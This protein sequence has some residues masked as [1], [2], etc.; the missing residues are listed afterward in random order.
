MASLPEIKQHVKDIIAK[1]LNL[2]SEDLDELQSFHNLGL[3]SVNSI[4]LLAK[5]EEKLDMYIDPLSVYD[6]PTIRS[7][8]EFL[9]TELS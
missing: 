9:H 4:F 3:D 5:M 8:S 6:N 7:F 2:N 1:E